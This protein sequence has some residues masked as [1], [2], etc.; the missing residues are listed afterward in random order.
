MKKKENNFMGG[1]LF[2]FM[3]VDWWGKFGIEEKKMRRWCYLVF[4]LKMM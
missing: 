1:V 2:L 4:V 3:F